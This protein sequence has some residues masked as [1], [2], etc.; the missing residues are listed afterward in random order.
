MLKH[1]FLSVAAVAVA[2]SVAGAQYQY[3][4]VYGRPAVCT[5]PQCQLRPVQAAVQAVGS[6]VQVVNDTVRGPAVPFSYAVT[7]PVVMPPAPAQLKTD[8]PMPAEAVRGVY[9]DGSR[10]TG[11]VPKAAPQA[12]PSAV[13]FVPGQPLRNALKAVKGAVL[14]VVK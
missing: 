8:A 9:P 3:P 1:Y 13:T 6:A 7:H 14:Y 4:V 11:P 10:S 2:G 12:M 5:G